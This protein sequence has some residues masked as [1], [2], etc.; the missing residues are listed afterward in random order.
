MMACIGIKNLDA[1]TLRC[2][3]PD[4]L[5]GLADLELTQVDSDHVL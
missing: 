5:V 1:L 4:P 3:F 2:S